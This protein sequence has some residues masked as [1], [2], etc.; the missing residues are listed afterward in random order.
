MMN[1]RVIS[2]ALV[3]VLGAAAAGRFRVIGYRGQ[4]HDS[5][6]VR[7]N[8]RLVQVYYSLGDF[9]KS[10]GVVSGDSQHILTFNIDLTVSASAKADLSAINSPSATQAQIT[11][12]LAASQDSAFE[13]DEAMDDLVDIIYQILMDG[14]NYDLDL[15][16]GTMSSRWVN[17][18]IKGEPLDK[19]GL[20][21]LTGQIQYTCQTVEEI[22]GDTGTPAGPGPFDTVVDIDGDDVERTGVISP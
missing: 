15:P 22:I 4:G 5:E 14:R 20:V 3:D 21:V 17:R 7:G 10:K 13:T 11:A 8:N 18:A 2:Q 12:A 16:L 1:F 6:E 9:P 19:G